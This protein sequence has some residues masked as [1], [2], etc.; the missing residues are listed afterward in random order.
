MREIKFRAWHFHKGW[1]KDGKDMPPGWEK[2]FYLTEDGRFTFPEG[3]WDLN[4]DMEISGTTGVLMQY[5]G[6]HDKNGKEIYEGDVVELKRKQVNGD[7]HR[8]VVEWDEM[9]A[10]FCLTLVHMY[11]KRQDSYIRNEFINAKNKTVIGNI[12]ENPEL[13]VPPIEE[14]KE[15]K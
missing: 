5:T 14:E 15:K 8:F 12:Y 13:L 7:I 9:K 2:G 11:P 10:G 1:K 6:L 4:G 3:G